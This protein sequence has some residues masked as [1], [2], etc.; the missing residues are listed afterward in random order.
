MEGE[1][2]DMKMKKLTAL[3]LAGVL[4][5]GMST[6]AFASASPLPEDAVTATQD[7]KDVNVY[8]SPIDTE[9]GTFAGWNSKKP[10]KVDESVRYTLEDRLDEIKK[11]LRDEDSLT[12]EE[13]KALKEEQTTLNELL[14]SD[15]KFAVVTL[16][17][18]TTDAVVDEENP[19]NIKFSLN[20]DTAWEGIQKGEVVRILHQVNGQMIVLEGTVQWN[21]KDGFFVEQEFDSL[22][23]IAILRFTDAAANGD[24]QNGNNTPNPTPNPGDDTTV[25]PGTNGN[26]TADQLADLIVKKLQNADASKVVRVVS[27]SKA[28]P[29]TGE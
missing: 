2:K 20:G 7:E 27:S 4:C 16:A 22:S 28:S 15:K 19:I 1:N 13:L 29:K 17:D 11:D 23:P 12:G 14:S 8:Q 9:T 26:I 10:E 18:I 3:A 6:T 24:D 25:T 5:L 21:E